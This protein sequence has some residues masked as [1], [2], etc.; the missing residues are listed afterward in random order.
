MY[1][2][3]PREGRK[4][5]GPVLPLLCVQRGHWVRKKKS[6]RTQMDIVM[7]THHPLIDLSL[8]NSWK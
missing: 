1:S 8:R 5:F 3:N 2:Y 6:N 4:R 7:S